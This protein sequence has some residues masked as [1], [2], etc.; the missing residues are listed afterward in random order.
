MIKFSVQQNLRSAEGVSPFETGSYR[1]SELLVPSG[2]AESR[3]WAVVH[4]KCVEGFSH[5]IRPKIK[6]FLKFST[7]KNQKKKNVF[8]CLFFLMKWSYQRN[9]IITGMKG[10]IQGISRYS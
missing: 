2:G 7:I 5:W 10:C 3:P 1:G 8:N 4:R 6:Q 9:V